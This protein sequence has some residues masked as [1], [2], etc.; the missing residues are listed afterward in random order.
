MTRALL[1]AAALVASAG[2]VLVQAETRPDPA[3]AALDGCG[4][5]RIAVIQKE[6]PN[7]AYVYDR[8]TSASDPPP[9][10]QWVEG[11]V[12]AGGESP[13][14]AHPTGVDDP[15]THDAY[16]FNV[17]VL[18]DPAF[19]FVLSGD[20]AARTG[21]FNGDEEELARLHM[22]REELGL[23][24]AVWPEQGDRVQALGSW[25][26]DCEH[27]QSGGSKTEFHPLRALWVERRFSPR[28]PSGESEGDLWYSNAKTPA[29]VEADCAHR[30]K[31][32]RAAFHACLPNEERVFDG[33]TV[34]TFALSPPASHAS[35]ATLRVRLVKVAATPGAPIPEVR[36][37]GGE[38]HVALAVSSTRGRP[39]MLA[40]EIFLGWTPTPVRLRPLHLGVSLDRL[41][42]RRA[43]DPSCPSTQ[44][45]CP[46][47][48]ETTQLSQ[49]AT[50]PGEWAF[51]ADVAGIWA[52]LRPLVLRVHDGQ[53]VRLR[54][55]VDLYV[56]P[57]KRWRLF[58]FTRECDFGRP[59]FD[60]PGNAVYPCPRSGEF[61]NPVGD[62]RP[63]YL[64][65]PGSV[66]L[67]VTNSSLDG[68]TCP[69][70]NTRGCYRLTWKVRKG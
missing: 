17:N 42:V 44:P 65:A 12:R 13:L 7:W 52:Q 30:T 27:F 31:G 61:G 8:R 1:L 53:R 6:Q 60:D 58:T 29:G 37:A 32:D 56:P 15:F 35:G 14:A 24:S 22:E 9:A 25:V 21:N 57:G 64:V 38:A 16:D 43:M 62:D 69:A 19:S 49:I 68:S 20:A 54:Y 47:A 40:Y 4:S 66:G 26:W 18:P 36:I 41:L 10:P 51:Y 2:A 33:S 5:E 59:T 48:G 50:A 46:F 28:S 63:G 45:T 67:H 34:R 70:S 39:I 11:R 3:Q 55:H 23:P